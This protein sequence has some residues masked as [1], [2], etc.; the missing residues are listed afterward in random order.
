[1]RIVFK[2]VYQF[3]VFLA[4]RSGG[5]ISEHDAFQLRFWMR[6]E[7]ALLRWMAHVS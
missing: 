6:A 7:E 3:R 4:P 2:T 1:M 5:P